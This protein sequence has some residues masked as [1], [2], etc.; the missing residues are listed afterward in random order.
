MWPLLVPALVGALA[1]FVASAVGRVVLA[2]GLSFVTYTGVQA[3]LSALK[4]LMI[5]QVNGLPLDVINLLGFLG[6]DKALT[7]IFSAFVF[8]VSLR[9]VNG[10]IKKAV[11]K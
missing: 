8:R 5:Q 2:L 3:G 9:L 11:F 4:T 7:V 1:T 6:I 10:V